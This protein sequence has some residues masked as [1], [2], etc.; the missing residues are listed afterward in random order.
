MEGLFRLSG[1]KAR[2]EELKCT[3]NR[4]EFVKLEEE[5]I[6]VITG[7]LKNFLQSLAEP[8]LTHELYRQ[9]MSIAGT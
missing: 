7:L 1:S 4:G 5:S 2:I 3:M 6:H 8:L 9:W